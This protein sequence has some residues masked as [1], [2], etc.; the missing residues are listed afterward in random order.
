MAPPDIGKCYMDVAFT[1]IGT[2]RDLSV[3]SQGGTD[4]ALNIQHLMFTILRLFVLWFFLAFDAVQS[5]TIR[6]KTG[7]FRG[8]RRAA[9][10]NLDFSK[11]NSH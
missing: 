8:K 2:S 11:K 9:F 10:V 4:I 6:T 5:D 1:A 3:I 7:S